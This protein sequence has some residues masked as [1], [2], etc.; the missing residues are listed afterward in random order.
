[1]VNVS[2]MVGRLTA[3]PELRKVGE[4]SVTLVTVALNK[5]KDEAY[6]VPV[7]VWG[8]EAEA[9][10][11]YCDKGSKIAVKG[12]LKTGKYT[13][14]EGKNVNTFAVCAESVEFCDGKKMEKNDR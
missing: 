4:T 7:E 8:R 5:T 3:K 12:Y 13:N 10:A 14:K 2:M 1:M 11:Q 6:F 9:L